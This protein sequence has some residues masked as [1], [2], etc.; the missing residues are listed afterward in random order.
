MLAAFYAL[1]VTA[2]IKYEDEEAAQH[3]LLLL[4][5]PPPLQ[6]TSPPPPPPQKK[7]QV[8][9][10]LNRKKNVRLG[11]SIPPSADAE[12][13]FELEN[14]KKIKYEKHKIINGLLLLPSIKQSIFPS[15]PSAPRT[16]AAAPLDMN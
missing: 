15:M 11:S 6:S 13:F 1:C 3:Q 4:L 10:D 9:S 8:D 16:A 14:E 2:K 7:M 5:P 12:M